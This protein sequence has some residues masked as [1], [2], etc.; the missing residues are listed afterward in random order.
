MLR[1]ARRA[2]LEARV[3]ALQPLYLRYSRPRPLRSAVPRQ[4]DKPS[5]RKDARLHQ[6]VVLRDDQVFQN[7]H[8]GEQP[9]VLKGAGNAGV[10]HNAETFDALELQDLAALVHGEPSGA[11][12][13]K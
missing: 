11:R 2:R 7:G 12:P 9:D 13:V 4:A 8:P 3:T 1:S 6:R 10:A 5:E